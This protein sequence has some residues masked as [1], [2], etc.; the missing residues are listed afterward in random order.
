MEH[1][2]TVL[3]HHSSTVDVPEPPHHQ[4]GDLIR[5]GTASLSRA[6]SRSQAQASDLSASRAIPHAPCGVGRTPQSGRCPRGHGRRGATARSALPPKPAVARRLAP[7]RRRSG[8]RPPGARR[9]TASRCPRCVRGLTV[10]RLGRSARGVR[11][12]GRPVADDA[13]V[14]LWFE[15]SADQGA[16]SHAMGVGGDL[17]SASRA[18]RRSSPLRP[19][20]DRRTPARVRT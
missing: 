14:S 20:P 16:P 10:S 13:R 3:T 18:D 5:T 9:R 8:F 11:P 1:G 6:T 7:A 15:R 4:D 2:R 17:K 12:R 19:R